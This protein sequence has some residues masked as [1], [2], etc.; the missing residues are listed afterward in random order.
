MS[1]KRYSHFCRWCVFIEYEYTS[2][3]DN[4]S[5]NYV[6]KFSDRNKSLLQNPMIVMEIVKL[7]IYEEIR[8]LS[9]I[10]V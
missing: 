1:L 9:Y 10:G 7:S 4:S 8:F 6:K 2:I 3:W 5:N